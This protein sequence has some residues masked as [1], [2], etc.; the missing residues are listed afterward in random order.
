MNRSKLR[1]NSPSKKNRPQ[2][3][4]ASRAGNRLP[5][6][7]I[8][9]LEG[10]WVIGIHSCSEA[11][12]IRPKACKKILVKEDISVFSPE[13]VTIIERNRLSVEPTKIST[14]DA[15]GSGHQGVAVLVNE[16]PVFSFDEVVSRERSLVVV[17]DE[18]SDPQNL[19]AILR[20]SWLLGVDALIL[21][22]D[23]AVGLT[24]VACKI[25]SGGAEHVP[26]SRVGN[27]AVTIKQFKEHGYWVYGLDEKGDQ[28]PA[29]VKFPQKAVWIVGAEEKGMRITTERVC[30]QLVSIPQVK[31]GSSYN[32]AVALTIALYETCRQLGFR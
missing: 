12:K 29:Q 8:S 31:S 10:R 18:L 28:S 11:L 21:P 6:K 23:R 15:F 26:V 14:L 3:A 2:G 5:P 13:V 17:L 32:A 22:S 27:L 4:G 30:D 7:D 19:G 25:A 1:K 20:T 24:P 9:S 16:D